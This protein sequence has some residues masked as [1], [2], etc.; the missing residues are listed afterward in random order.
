MTNK[1][2]DRV[3]LTPE[4]WQKLQQAF[5]FEPYQPSDFV[6]QVEGDLYQREPQQFNAWTWVVAGLTKLRAYLPG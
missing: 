4:D 1:N 5:D 2:P 6:P 3:P